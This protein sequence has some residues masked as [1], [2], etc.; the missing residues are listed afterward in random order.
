[1]WGSERSIVE[2]GVAGE[3]RIALEKAGN[4]VSSKQA[5]SRGQL[6]SNGVGRKI[7]K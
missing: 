2:L 3:Y 4:V 7:N 5:V 1:M 6:W